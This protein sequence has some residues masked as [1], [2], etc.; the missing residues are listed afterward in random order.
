MCVFEQRAFRE[1]ARWLTYGFEGD[2]HLSGSERA[3]GV[4]AKNRSNLSEE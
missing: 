2:A 1:R 4:G 3:D